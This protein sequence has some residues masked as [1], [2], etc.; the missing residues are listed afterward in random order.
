MTVWAQ[1]LKVLHA[2]IES[3][4][5][6]VVKGK[7]QGLASPFGYPAALAPLLFETLT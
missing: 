4:A 1:E 6:D 3:V 7:G 5:I 2:I